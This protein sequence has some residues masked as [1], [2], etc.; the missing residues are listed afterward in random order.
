MNPAEQV[1]RE[2][3]CTVGLGGVIVLTVWDSEADLG[4]A[5]PSSMSLDKEVGWRGLGCARPSSMS[6][7]KEVGWRVGVRVVWLERSGVRG[8]TNPRCG[9]RRRG[10]RGTGGW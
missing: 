9:S 10:V 8:T 3:T 4:C 1:P 2:G 6:L 5:R 7:D